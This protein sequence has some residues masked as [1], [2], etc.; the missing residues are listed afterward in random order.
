MKK[1]HKFTRKNY[2]LLVISVVAV[3]SLGTILII[4]SKAATPYGTKEVDNATLSGAATQQTDSNAS[5]GKYIRFGAVAT[6][7]PS[8]PSGNPTWDG[9]ADRGLLGLWSQRQDSNFTDIYGVPGSTTVTIVD[10]PVLPGHKAFRFWVSQNYASEI[11]PRAELAANQDLNEGDDLWFG[12]VLYIPSN[13]NRSIGWGG[14]H[15]TV[16]QFKNEGTGSPPLNFEIFNFGTGSNLYSQEEGNGVPGGQHYSLVMSEANLYD[17]AIPIEIHVHFSSNP[18]VG[19]YEVWADG[20]RVIAP[21]HFATL[22]PGLKDGLKQGQYGESPGNIVYW[23]G[24]YRGPTRAS[25]LR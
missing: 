14:T 19:E 21:T 20:N 18:S 3:A 8:T 15:H 23:H 7:P 11:G 22:F 6:P 10:S 17:R 12:D 24:A 4:N 16:L 25:V 9:S 13:P 2:I 5:S 1:L